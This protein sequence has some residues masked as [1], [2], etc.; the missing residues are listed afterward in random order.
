M[1]PKK[2]LVKVPEPVLEGNNKVKCKLCGTNANYK[3]ED[4]LNHKEWCKLA[5]QQVEAAAAAE[6]KK[7]KKKKGA[8]KKKKGAHK[9]NN[10]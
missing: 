8:H 6:A 3:M 10:N 4:M 1:P 5:K 2:K 7:K 9:N